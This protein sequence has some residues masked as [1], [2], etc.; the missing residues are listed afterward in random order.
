MFGL[1]DGSSFDPVS[2]DLAEYSTVVPNAVTVPFEGYRRDGGTVTT[3]A[4]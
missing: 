3:R 1:N 2:V 4:V